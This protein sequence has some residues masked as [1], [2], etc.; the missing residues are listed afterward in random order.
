MVYD[1]YHKSVMCESSTEVRWKEMEEYCLGSYTIPKVIYHHL[2][3]GCDKL[4]VC[5]INP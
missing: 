2:K 1:I 5:P 4:K 3:L